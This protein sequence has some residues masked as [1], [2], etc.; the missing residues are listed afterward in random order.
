[1]PA[2]SA[3]ARKIG[4][5]ELGDGTVVAADRQKDRDVIGD[6]G[7]DAAVLE[8]QQ[9]FGQTLIGL[10]V[11]A[12]VTRPT[13]RGVSPSVTPMVA[14]LRSSIVAMSLPSATKTP[15]LMR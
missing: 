6:D 4:R 7:I 2:S 11:V 3:D 12:L 5:I 10:D 1:M 15:R 8:F 14:S 13:A 9:Q